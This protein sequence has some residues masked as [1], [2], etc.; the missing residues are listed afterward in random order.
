MSMCNSVCKPGNVNGN[1]PVVCAIK[2]IKCQACAKG[3]AVVELH[4]ARMQHLCLDTASNGNELH[5]ELPKDGHCS[6]LNSLSVYQK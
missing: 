4:R 3:N 5:V 2:T 1:I 6:L